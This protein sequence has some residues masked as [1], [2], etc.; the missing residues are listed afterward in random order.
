MT[1]IRGFDS[2]YDEEPIEVSLSPNQ[3]LLQV[4]EENRR[5]KEAERQQRLAQKVTPIIVDNST[6]SVDSLSEPSPSPGQKNA[7]GPANTSGPIIE[8]EPLFES[9]PIIEPDPQIIPGSTDAPRSNILPEPTFQPGPN[10]T[11][12]ANF[13]PDPITEPRTIFTPG[14]IA[15]EITKP[16]L[17]KTSIGP[18]ITPHPNIQPGPS[19]EPAPKIQ[20]GP[21]ILSDS[22]NAPGPIF[23]PGPKTG[24]DLMIVWNYCRRDR[25][26]AKLLRDLSPSEF[27]IYNYF[28]SRTYEDYT[29]KQIC[30]TT[31]SVISL[32]TNISKNTVMASIKTLAQKG[33]LKRIVTGSQ[34]GDKSLYRVF[35]PCESPCYESSTQFINGDHDSPT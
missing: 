17:Q 27:K 3:R 15:L 12:E 24:T 7:P 22:Q 25:D 2:M 8:P 20:P 26:I 34:A 35:L 9:D 32:E 30:N 14:S 6:I 10:F 16:Q 4:A 13:E 1:E 18:T 21:K 29:P 19:I 5:K 28:L 23:T 31:N 11:P 33:L